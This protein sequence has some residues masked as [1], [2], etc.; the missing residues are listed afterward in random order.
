MCYQNNKGAVGTNGK[1][2][3]PAQRKKLI[4]ETVACMGCIQC[5]EIICEDCCWKKGY[6]EHEGM[7]KE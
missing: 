6:D 2:V 1:K 4:V 7:S 5:D 3:T